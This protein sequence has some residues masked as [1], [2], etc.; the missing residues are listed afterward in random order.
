M[1][2]SEASLAA[3]EEA[4]AGEKMEADREIQNLK[5]WV[6]IFYIDSK[7]ESLIK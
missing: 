6:A 4:W 5:V 2:Q 7:A 3:K 1:Q